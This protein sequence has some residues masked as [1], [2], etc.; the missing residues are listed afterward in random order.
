MYRHWQNEVSS[1][2]E[3]AAANEPVTPDTTLDTPP[4]LVGGFPVV[5]E[6]YEFMTALQAKNGSLRFGVNRNTTSKWAVFGGASH[7]NEVFLQLL[8]YREGDV[9]AMGR[10]GYHNPNLESRRSST[11]DSA[12]TVY[13]RDIENTKYRVH[14][15]AYRTRA[16]KRLNAAVTLALK[17]LKTCTP[18]EIANESKLD[19][20]LK[21]TSRVRD[22]ESKL[23]DVKYELKRNDSGLTNLVLTELLAAKNKGYSFDSPK[24]KEY[25]EK[26]EAAYTEHEAEGNRAV[27]SYN[28]R[29]YEKAG[30]VMADV[31]LFSDVSDGSLPTNLQTIPV[32]D[33]PEDIAGKLAVLDMLAKDE[34][35]ENVGVNVGKGVYW[36]DRDAV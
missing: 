23:I 34:Y 28:V 14:N 30:V 18:V 17:H 7:I 13:S 16:S 22:L 2:A 20:S 10:I 8:V 19:Y 26:Y 12:Y 21:A 36:V 31:L 15:A 5:K 1:I 29:L 6:L 27:S 35:V 25:V 9:Y 32:A 33:M 3:Y 4:Y 24:V 11:D